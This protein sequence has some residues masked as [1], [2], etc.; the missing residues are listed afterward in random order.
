MAFG[1][2]TLS[3]HSLGRLL[4]LYAVKG[5]V[6][7]KLLFEGTV[8]AFGDRV[9]VWAGALGHADLNTS[10]LQ[11]LHVVGAA[12]LHSSVGVVNQLPSG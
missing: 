3:S 6:H 9:L 7:I 12:I 5:L 10:I 11:D 2:C 4:H 8:D 1:D